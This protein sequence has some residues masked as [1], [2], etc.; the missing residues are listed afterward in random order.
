MLGE[1]ALKDKSI[2]QSCEHCGYP[3]FIQPPK[4]ARCNHVHY[5][6]ACDV[7]NDKAEMQRP[8]ITISKDEYEQLLSIAMQELVQ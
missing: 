6:E 3:T 8:N 2:D 7:C 5:P 1:T 4:K